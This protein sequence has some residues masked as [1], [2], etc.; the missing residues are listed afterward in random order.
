MPTVMGVSGDAKTQE[1]C[2]T[3]TVEPLEVEGPVEDLN[4]EGEKE[5]EKPPCLSQGIQVL[6]A[7]LIGGSI[8]I[9]FGAMGWAKHET[10]TILALFGKLWLKAL[11]CIVLPMI[12]FSMVDAMVMMRSLPGAKMVGFT[13][14]GLYLATTV[15]AA[16]EG[17]VVS[18]LILGPFVSPINLTADADGPTTT[19]KPVA[20][21]SAFET[22]L[23][24]F[25]NLV[26]KNLVG[27]AANNN[28]LPVIVASIVFGLL[29]KDKEAD[30]TKSI[31][32]RG[33]DQLNEVVVKVVT[34]VMMVTP[35][36]V[37]SLVFA[38]TA[39]LDLAEMGKN[40]GFLVITVLAGLSLHVGGTLTLMLL[41]LARRSPCSYFRKVFPAFATALGTASSA[42]SLPVTRSCAVL[43]NGITPHIADFVLSLG[44]TINMDGTSIYLICACFFLGQLQGIAFGAAD[45][46]TM[47]LLAT[48]CSMG[49]APVPSASLVLLAT[50]MT[51]V[52]V[53]F[54]ETFGMISAVDWL[55]DRF[56]TSVNVAGDSAITAIVDRYFG[57]GGAEVDEER[58]NVNSE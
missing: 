13:V 9:A 12:M 20:Q 38:S 23:S 11:K 22:I 21:R 2:R 56:R 45:F 1:E 39:R 15:M 4:A 24:I 17:C 35:I 26:P 40:V 47:A 14:I 27:E 32:L 19:P 42:A 6:I 50:I 3:F 16:I 54:N 29:V 34:G 46:I 7:V 58:Q 36:G 48:F 55:L 57:E 53:P 37:G 5:D 25:D 43:G 44:A 18:A 33:I 30:G 41:F 31:I 52:G 51:A 10:A 8:G 28:L 49:A